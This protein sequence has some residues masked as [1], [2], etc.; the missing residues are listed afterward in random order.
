MQIKFSKKALAYAISAVMVWAFVPVLIMQLRK[1]P[2][3]EMLCFTLSVSF[4]T[5]LIYN[6]VKGEKTFVNM[7]LS[8]MIPVGM[9]AVS[10]PSYFYIMA[11]KY[12]PATHVELIMYIW[13]MIVIIGNVLFYSLKPNW[14]LVLAILLAVTAL[15]S[16]HYDNFY[17]TSINGHILRGYSFVLVA[18]FCWSIYNLCTKGYG[19][20][21]PQTM[22]VYG[23]FCIPFA[24]VL[25]FVFENN[26]QPSFLEMCIIL[27]IGFLSHWYAFFAWDYAVKK[28]D[29]SIMAIIAYTTPVISF[30]FLYLF[31]Y[32]SLSVAIVLAM[33]L[34]FSASILGYFS[35]KNQIAIS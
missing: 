15:F 5:T 27:V 3:L 20:I 33:V 1:F 29:A 34:I 13:P 26:I 17:V 28:V 32:A 14:K 24:L 31:G 35:T 8:Y 21:S 11:F 4:V 30:I 9:L 7:K 2:T 12:A 19:E 23:G 25:H 10:A 18:A 16:L 6:R 22:G